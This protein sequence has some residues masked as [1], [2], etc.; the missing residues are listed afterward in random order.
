MILLS[1][2]PT[3]GF[4]NIRLRLRL[5]IR[6]NG[7]TTERVQ[8][9]PFMLQIR[10]LETE[11]RN[12]LVFTQIRWD[13][14]ERFWVKT[15]S[16]GLTCSRMAIAETDVCHVRHFNKLLSLNSLLKPLLNTFQ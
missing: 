5:Q 3:S 9:Y 13:V 15:E 7:T 8:P 16:P 2:D 4:V 11:T 10:Y 1:I 6:A 14:L 12:L